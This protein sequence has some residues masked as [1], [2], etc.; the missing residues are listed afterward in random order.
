MRADKLEHVFN[1]KKIFDAIS[2]AEPKTE[3]LADISDFLCAVKSTD[4][5]L[6]HSSS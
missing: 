6:Q 2:D 5:F 4:R 1:K 3:P